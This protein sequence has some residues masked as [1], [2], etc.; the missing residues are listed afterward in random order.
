MGNA[1]IR[2]GHAPAQVFGRY[3]LDDSL[4]W[5]EELTRLLHVWMVMCRP[6][7]KRRICVSTCC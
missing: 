4:V 7:S 3:V 1:V 5:S 2:T 6:R